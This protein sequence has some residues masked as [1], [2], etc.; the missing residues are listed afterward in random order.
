MSTV[1]V[2]MPVYNTDEEYLRE[3]IESI[4]NQTY[5]D[6]EFVIIDDGSTNN[7]PEVMQE[8]ASNDSRLKIIKGE[9]K[10]IGA[11]L[12]KGLEVANGEFVARM[13]SDDISLPHRFETQ[14]KYLDNNE[15]V[16]IVGSQIQKFPNRG[17]CR[18]IEEVS[19]LSLIK[20]CMVAHPTVMFRK[21]DFDKFGLRYNEEWRV[22]EDYELWSRAVKHLKIRNIN[23]V[24]LN[25]RVLS[26]GNSHKNTDRIFLHDKQIRERL[27]N[28][29]TLDKKLQDKIYDAIDNYYSPHLT[30]GE[31]IFSVKNFISRNTKHK[32]ITILGIQVK[33]K[34]RV[35]CEAI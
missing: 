9:H 33:F 5:T 15:D 19:Y 12:N 28:E 27:M 1:S 7:A 6:F 29:L 10:G 21:S 14:V 30:I 20:G 3:S 34:K 31:R 22:S 32:M 8:Y 16:S 11:A 13:D 23:E 2:I 4:L 17:I 35:K 25:Y 24:L 18:Y 26:T